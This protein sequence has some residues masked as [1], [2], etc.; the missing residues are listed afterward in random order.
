[1]S[2]ELT[3]SG[4]SLSYAKNHMGIDHGFLFQEGDRSRV[5]SEQISY[6]WYEEHPEETAELDEHEAAFVR[7]LRSVL[8]RLDLLGHTLDTAR[9]EY[10]AI[11]GEEVGSGSECS[12]TPAHG[13]M[14]FDEFCSFAVA[15]RCRSWMK[16]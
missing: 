13:F 12:P 3:V 1:M 14:S 4:V 16:P 2:I 9:S 8:P 10:E 15:Y 7:P 11:V 6:E 5:K